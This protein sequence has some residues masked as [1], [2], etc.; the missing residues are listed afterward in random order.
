M[1]KT[2]FVL[3]FL[4]L[5]AVAFA[6][7]PMEDVV[8]LKNGS[9]I[10]GII[11]EQK[12]GESLKI[13]LLGGSIFVFQQ[14]EI[15]SVK[16]EAVIATAAPNSKKEYFRKDKG[17]R[18][19]TELGIICGFGSN[20]TQQYYYGSNT[21]Q[22]DFGVSLHTINGYQFSRWL[23]VGG[24]VGIDRFIT[25]KQ[26]F[27]PFYL[28]VASEFLKKRATPYIYADLGYA[29]MWKFKSDEYTTYNNQGGIYHGAGGGVRIYT[30][31][32]A[33]VMMGVGYRRNTSET[34]WQYA[35]EGSPVYNLQR[36]YQRVVF[37][38]CVSF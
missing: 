33:S 5:S 7:T 35:Y 18:S 28:R 15:D 21:A 2:L 9:V 26:T 1:K 31:G 22:S 20:N 25:Y 37:S 27:S 30:Q 19:I 23:F 17:Y 8:Y 29:H 34:T 38:M 16:K 11:T 13:K 4:L 6:Q 12:I 10:R 14:N 36:A 3:S 32:R 24:G